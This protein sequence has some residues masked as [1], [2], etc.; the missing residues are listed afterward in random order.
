MSY[1]WKNND[2]SL[3]FRVKLDAG[4]SMEGENSI[5][6]QAAC[7]ATHNHGNAICQYTLNESIGGRQRN[8]LSLLKV[9]EAPYLCVKPLGFFSWDEDGHLQTVWSGSL[10]AVAGK[11]DSTDQRCADV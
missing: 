11:N 6:V 1:N 5:L 10:T 4:R 9:V 8:Q 3:L 7:I 2:K